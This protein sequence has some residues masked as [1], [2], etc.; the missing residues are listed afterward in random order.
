M[1]IKF[2]FVMVTVLTLTLV[3]S[4]L[5]AF[6]SEA[7][8]SESFVKAQEIPVNQNAE[9]MLAQSEIES[10]IEGNIDIAAETNLT[11]DSTKS[12]KSIETQTRRR[13][14]G[15]LSDNPRTIVN[16][17][18]TQSNDVDFHFFSVT[19]NKFLLA[20]LISDNADYWTALYIVDYETGTATPTNVGN[21]SGSLIA[22]NGLP[23]GDYAFAVASDGTLGDSYS[24]RINAANPAGSYSNII[25]V[26]PSLQQ[27]VVL[28]SNN[29]VYANGTFVYNTSSSAST[30]HLDW[31]R[32]YYFSYGGNYNQRTHNIS[33]AK[34]K[35]V[36]GPYSYSSS[37]AS[38]NNV[39]LIYLDEDTLFTYF[40]SQFQSYPHYYYSSFVDILGKT[41]P[42][43]L[44]ADD[45]LY[46]EHIIA[47]DLNTG[48]P[49]DFYSVLNFYYG[50][51]IEN[52][53][54]ITELT[55]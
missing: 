1:S 12:I 53:P 19:S 13:A 5:P 25:K 52:L 24:L 30:Q 48:T 45:Y 41:T 4:S 40:E 43:R 49:I 3:F 17:T 15:L 39:M 10:E 7:T 35:A 29:D 18:L 47:Y 8:G 26:T 33:Y 2:K 28:Y 22:L 54:T 46:G 37:Y 6:A 34:I 42:R 44:E 9:V 23:Q 38:S 55:E 16:G 14:S 51:G 32:Q 21:Y 27:F 31:Q 50:A 20:Q 36:A 11:V